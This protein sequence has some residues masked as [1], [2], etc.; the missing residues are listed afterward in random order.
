MSAYQHTPTHTSTNTQEL[1]ILCP[2]SFFC[3]SFF[4]F[5]FFF[6]FWISTRKLRQGFLLFFF[7]LLYLIIYFYLFFYFVLLFFFFAN[8]K[9]FSVIPI[10][11]FELQFWTRIPLVFFPCFLLFSPLTLPFLL[12]FL[13][14]FY[15]FTFPS[16]SIIQSLKRQEF[17]RKTYLQFL[18]PNHVVH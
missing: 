11:T 4:L 1:Q 2:F 10:S 18:P 14:P 5:L 17:I 6:F 13:F 3:S 7:T 12:L 9:R 8:K 16:K 15:P